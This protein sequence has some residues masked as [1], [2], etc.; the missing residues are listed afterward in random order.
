MN[1]MDRWA[2]VK[3]REAQGDARLLASASTDPVPPDGSAPT[4]PSPYAI[5]VIWI[6]GRWWPVT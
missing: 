2:P 3:G 1:P 4:P 5:D 6:L